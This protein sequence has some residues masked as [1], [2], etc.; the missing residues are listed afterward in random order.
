VNIAPETRPIAHSAPKNLTF[1]CN[2]DFRQPALGAQFWVQKL[3]PVALRRGYR[4]QTRPIAWSAP[5]SAAP[6]PARPAPGHATPRHGAVPRGLIAATCALHVAGRS[7][8]PT[9][10]SILPRILSVFHTCDRAP[11]SGSD[12]ITGPDQLSNPLALKVGSAPG[13]YATT[14]D[15]RT[16]LPPG[17]PR[18]GNAPDVGALPA[19]SRPPGT[20]TLTTTLR[21]GAARGPPHPTVG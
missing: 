5:K 2:A 4:S 16:S 20:P 15:L 7:G 19:P 12:Y 3:V 17:R 1:L 14:A 9:I 11:G 18:T 10:C 8:S 21:P 6:S 13:C